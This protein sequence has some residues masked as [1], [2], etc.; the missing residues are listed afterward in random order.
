MDLFYNLDQTYIR[1]DII[2]QAQTKKPKTLYK[3]L[4][5]LPK[6]KHLTTISK[7]IMWLMLLKIELKNQNQIETDVQQ[8][9]AYCELN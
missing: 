6:Q 4:C 8:V 5:V 7:V 3:W 1:L 9:H 2:Y